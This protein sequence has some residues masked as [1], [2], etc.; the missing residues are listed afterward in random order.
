M[1]AHAAIHVLL[2][3]PQKRSLKEKKTWIPAFARM[4]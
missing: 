2:C 4:T 1:A 3:L